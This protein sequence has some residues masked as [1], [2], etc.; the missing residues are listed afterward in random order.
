MSFYSNTPVMF[1]G[2]SATTL[3]PGSKD[4][5][6]GTRVNYAGNE[7]VYA[8]NASSDSAMYPGMVGTPVTGGSSYSFTISTAAGLEAP[9]GVC[10]NATFA[11]GAYGFLL[12]RGYGTAYVSAAVA[13]GVVL[14]VAANGI[15]TT[16]VTFP[17][18]AKLMAAT[19][20]ATN[21]TGSAFFSF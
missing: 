7:Y 13:A 16:A 20:A 5:E 21:V 4:P 6:L 15:F 12:V 11:T 3:T 10:K 8:Y 9:M 14:Q 19:S 18:T 17:V 2:V 1:S